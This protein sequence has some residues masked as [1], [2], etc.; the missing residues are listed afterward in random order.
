MLVLRKEDHSMDERERRVLAVGAYLAGAAPTEVARTVGRTVRWLLKWARRYREGRPDWAQDRSRA[1]HR[2]PGRSPTWVERLIVRVRRTLM[3]RPR[4]QHG[5][6]AIRHVLAERGVTPLPRVGLINRVLTRHGLVS[7][8][9]R[10]FTPKGLPY[11]AI[12][13]TGVSIGDICPQN[14]EIRCPPN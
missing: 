5:A 1:P 2:M 13:P 4:V 10:R 3:T 9:Q 7:R 11:P 14:R 8:R 12:V 6:Q